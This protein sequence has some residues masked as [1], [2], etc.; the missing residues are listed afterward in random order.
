MRDMVLADGTI[1]EVGMK[2]R[3]ADGCANKWASYIK[4]YAVIERIK[5]NGWCECSFPELSHTLSIENRFLV[6]HEEC[7]ASFYA[8]D[9]N[10]TEFLSMIGGE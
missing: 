1:A 8:Q 10:E 3:K 7:C 4:S 2:V 5:D 6:Q 9:F